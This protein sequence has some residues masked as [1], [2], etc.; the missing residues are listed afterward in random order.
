MSFSDRNNG[1]DELGKNLAALMSESKG[2]NNRPK[3][4]LQRVA[5]KQ[6]IT[7]I[8]EQ[9]GEGRSENHR[10]TDLQRKGGAAGAAASSRG[11]SKKK[12]HT[13]RAY[14]FF[15]GTHEKREELFLGQRDSSIKLREKQDKMAH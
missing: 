8:S 7:K 4:D 2:M 12:D 13:N 15:R 14:E 1:Q 10:A 11:D 9:T 3:S 6:D 5:I